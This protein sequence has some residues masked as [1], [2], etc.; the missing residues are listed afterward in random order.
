MANDTENRDQQ[1]TPRKA[2]GDTD[3]GTTINSENYLHSGLLDTRDQHLDK[4][5]DYHLT[6]DKGLSSE[7]VN[8]NL[9]LGSH[10][11]DANIAE[12]SGQAP[13]AFDLAK[14]ISGRSECRSSRQTADRQTVSCRQ[15][16][17]CPGPRLRPD[18]HERENNAGPSPSNSGTGSQRSEIDPRPVQSE[19]T[20]PQPETNGTQADT[21]APS[22]QSAASQT[23][24]VETDTV[25]SGLTAI[26]DTD[27]DENAVN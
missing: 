8:S 4:A 14:D 1:T 13:Q 25:G 6:Q 11:G 12:E 3:S 7:Q 10:E 23:S 16:R 17:A 18:L 24:E 20:N 27:V 5:H 2:D 21:P 15:R 9:H 22:S 26:S 19:A